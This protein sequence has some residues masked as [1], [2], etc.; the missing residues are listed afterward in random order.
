M[1]GHDAVIITASVSSLSEL[2][3]IPDYFSRGT[4]YCIDAMK[5]SGV[6]RLI[7]LS[8]LGAGDSKPH[9]GWFLRTV[10][11]NGILKRAFQ[12][13]DVQERLTE[14][15]KLEWTIARPGRLTNG[16]AKGR[17]VR[18]DTPDAKVP[19]SISRADVADFMVDAC[20]A[21]DTI[22]KTFSLGG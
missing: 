17:V 11:I 5:A 10:V 22:G 16:P 7:V 19:S 6:K 21:R 4:R 20:T 15:S 13:H 2:K 9:A 3:A 12:D 14:E 8:A 18:A 1:P